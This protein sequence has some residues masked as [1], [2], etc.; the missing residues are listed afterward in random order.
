[1]ALDPFYLGESAIP[2]RPYLFALLVSSVQE[3][4]LGIQAGQIAAVARW[5]GDVHEQP[6][7]VDATGMRS[8]L[9]ALVAGALEPKTSSLTLH[10]SLGSLREVIEK[11]LGVDQA[12]ELFCFG[13]LEQFDIRQLAA[14]LASREL[15]FPD[16]SERVREEVGNLAEWFERHGGQLSIGNR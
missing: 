11:D 8:S 5:L 6:V 2:A 4:P 3:R 15:R 10:G 7:R 13:L 9:A 14:L 1:M 16:A 12:P